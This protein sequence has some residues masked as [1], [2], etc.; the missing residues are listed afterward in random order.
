M[1]KK[2]LVYSTPT[3]MYCKMVKEYFEENSVAFTEF[4][5]TVD[6]KARKDMMDKT[7]QMGVPVIDIEGELIIG[8]DKAKIAEL[9]GLGA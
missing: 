7:G 2:V 4:D 6:E 9:L 3:C 5:V 8:F 1:E